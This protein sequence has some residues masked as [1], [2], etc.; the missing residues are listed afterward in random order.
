M[1]LPAAL[2]VRL[3][4]RRSIREA[5]AALRGRTLAPWV[6][7][8]LSDDARPVNA[9][10]VRFKIWYPLLRHAGVRDVRLHDLR[11]TYASLL[12]QAGEPLGYVKTQLGHSSIQVTVDRYG[13]FIP[14]AN[15]QAVERLAQATTARDGA[16]ELQRNFDAAPV[17]RDAE[18]ADAG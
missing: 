11:H 14:G 18:E 6:F 12:L 13:H 2:V 4:E 16:V 1:D 9:A 17:R 7:P 8:A 15:R 10:Y 5:E 3:C